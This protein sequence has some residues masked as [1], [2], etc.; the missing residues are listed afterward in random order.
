MRALE[1]GKRFI[2]RA[3][4]TNHFPRAILSSKKGARGQ[5]PAKSRSANGRGMGEGPHSKVFR[6]LKQ[7][8]RTWWIRLLVRASKTR[9]PHPLL[10]PFPPYVRYSALPIV[11]GI[12][13]AGGRVIASLPRKTETFP[14]VKE[15]GGRGGGRKRERSADNMH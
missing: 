8:P 13:S 2:F 12:V 1:K 7:I 6:E 11:A 15:D 9:L 10:F 3:R 4:R 5:S 14:K